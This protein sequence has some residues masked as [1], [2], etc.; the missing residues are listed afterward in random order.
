MQQGLDAIASLS[1]Q[2]DR[3]QQLLTAVVV[4]SLGHMGD[5]LTTSINGWL[6]PAAMAELAAAQTRML[7]EMPLPAEV[8]HSVQDEL[9]AVAAAELHHLADSIIQQREQRQQQLTPV[10]SQEELTNV[11]WV[12]YPFASSA[13][14]SYH[15]PPADAG[16]N[17]DKW[18]P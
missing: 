11:C 8:R 17:L 14:N 18:Q 7:A 6:P 15:L 10:D 3:E 16:R 1:L 4:P 2:P 9:A 13:C 5:G 12:C